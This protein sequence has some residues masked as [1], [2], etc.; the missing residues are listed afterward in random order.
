[1]KG[2][3][4]AATGIRNR[5]CSF[6]DFRTG[7]ARGGCEPSVGPCAVRF[8][9]RVV[10]AQ[11][12][13]FSMR[14]ACISPATASPVSRRQRRAARGEPLFFV[15]GEELLAIAIGHL[16]NLDRFRGE[17]LPLVEREEVEIA[18]REEMTLRLVCGF[19]GHI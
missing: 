4:N 14:E 17:L 13:S 19:N 18:S 10:R 7:M 9:L 11:R 1:M 8:E 15:A 6:S 16:A 12:L 3:G 2:E 5:V